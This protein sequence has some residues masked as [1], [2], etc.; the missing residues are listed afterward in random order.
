M[1]D[2][3]LAEYDRALAK[4]GAAQD[5][6]AKRVRRSAWLLHARARRLLK[7]RS[8]SAKVPALAN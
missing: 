7:N 1:T 4:K 2:R 3:Y 8:S 6:V 5:S